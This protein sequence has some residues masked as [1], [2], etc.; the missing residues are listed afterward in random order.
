M[1]AELESGC[2]HMG[3]TSALEMTMDHVTEPRMAAP[4]MRPPM[5]MPEETLTRPTTTPTPSR[6]LRSKRSC[7]TKTNNAAMK[8]PA[9]SVL[10]VKIPVQQWA[11]PPDCM[12]HGTLIRSM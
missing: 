2:H 7:R 4:L 1:L 12:L 10:L 5:V 11:G 3:H 9:G 8:T 6:S